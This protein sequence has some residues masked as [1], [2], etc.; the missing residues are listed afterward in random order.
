MGRPAFLAYRAVVTATLVAVGLA[1]GAVI[2]REDAFG[3]RI[4]VGEGLLH[5]MLDILVALDTSI[6]RYAALPFQPLIELVM[7]ERLSPATAVL[8][9]AAT[10][11][12]I[13]L[14]AAVIGLYSL[15]TRQAARRERSEYANS[16]CGRRR[17]PSRLLARRPRAHAASA[18]LSLPR[19][20][21]LG[22]AGGAG[23]AA[24]GRRTAPLG[25]L[26]DGD[27]R[28]GGVRLGAV[29]RDRRPL[30]RATGHDRHA[31]VLHVSAVAHGAAI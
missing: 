5:R 10:G 20:A 12:V 17:P 29:L 4:N 8:A 28:A 23:V 24:T 11:G 27:D 16:P 26:V 14:A 31:G 1:A 18:G 3:G 22:G 9:A 15:V 6:F 19:I 13:A 25:E 2:V 21:H 30:Y 7:A